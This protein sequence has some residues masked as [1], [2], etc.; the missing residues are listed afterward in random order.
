M[1]HGLQ[2]RRTITVVA[3]VAVGFP[4]ER[5]VISPNAA[6]TVASPAS[7]VAHNVCQSATGLLSR[8]ERRSRAGWDKMMHGATLYAL[9]INVVGDC[10]R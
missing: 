6:A 2:T 1:A 5:T 9:A 8:Q 7:S 3:V 10:S 4:E